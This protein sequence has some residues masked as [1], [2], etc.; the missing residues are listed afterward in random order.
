MKRFTQ[1][2]KPPTDQQTGF[3]DVIT[4]ET[5]AAVEIVL[6]QELHGVEGRSACRANRMMYCLVLHVWW[7]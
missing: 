4:K 2:R 7:Y 1:E 3:G 5:N 6:K